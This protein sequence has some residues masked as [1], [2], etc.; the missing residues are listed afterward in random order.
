MSTKS[1]CVLL[2]SGGIDSTTLLAKLV[3]EGRHPLC[4]I[5]DYGQS[6]I[7]E[8]TVAKKNAE[9]YGCESMVLKTPLNF[10]GG[11]CSLLSGKDGEIVTGRSRGEIAASGTPSSYVPF[12]NGIFLAYAV[13]L[14]EAKGLREIYCGGNGL[15]S[16]N[17]YDDTAAF[18]SAFTDAAREGT[19]PE[20]MPT[21]WFPFSMISKADVVKIGNRLR[22]DYGLTWSCYKNNVRPC[23]E[24][25]SCVQREDAMLNSVI[26]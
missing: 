2:L 24:C 5:F 16:G 14:G 6:L 11:V 1:D 18:A 12:R 7:K 23:G 9:R 17:Y 22:V 26:Y 8:V 4:L 10:L 3:A 25:D 13:A 21:I 20:Y 15:S 19:S